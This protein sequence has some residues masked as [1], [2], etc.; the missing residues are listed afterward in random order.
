MD[1][2][3]Y[4]LDRIEIDNTAISLGMARGAVEAAIGAGQTI[5]KRHYYY[6]NDMA[7]DYNADDRVEFIEF[8]GGVDGSLKPVI[9]GVSAFDAN[10]DQLAQ[11]L[12]EGN[13]GELTDNEQGHSYLFPNISVSVYREITPADVAEMIEEMQADGIPTEN[14]IDLEHDK[15]RAGH[16]SAIG[17]GVA[18]YYR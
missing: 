5:G 6:H 17:I 12:K 16:W 13:G 1:I 18:G 3:L 2:K 10:A 7:I 9:F 14:N 8:L 4:P 11:L 15:R